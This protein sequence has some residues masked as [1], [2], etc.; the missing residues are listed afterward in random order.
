MHSNALTIDE[1][2]GRGDWN[3]TKT[4]RSAATVGVPDSVIA[5]IQRL[6]TLEAILFWISQWPSRRDRLAEILPCGR[7]KGMEKKGPSPS[8]ECWFHQIECRD[9][10]EV[11]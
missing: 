8:E 2:Y 11:P 5:R 10:R 6:K 9:C 4:T 3:R 1:R 7:L